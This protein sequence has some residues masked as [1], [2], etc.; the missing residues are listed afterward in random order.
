M[1][2]QKPW[3]IAPLFDFN[4]SDD[5]KTILDHDGFCLS[6]KKKIVKYDHSKF[7]GFEG[8]VDPGMP[9]HRQQLKDVSYAVHADEEVDAATPQ[10]ILF[11]LKLIRDTNA[12]LVCSFSRNGANRVDRGGSQW[13]LF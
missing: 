12:K 3:S 11:F 2:D 4:V 9:Q 5:L 6:E 1:T 13:K 7:T 10:T 8:Y